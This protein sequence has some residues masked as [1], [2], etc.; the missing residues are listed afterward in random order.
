MSEASSSGTS[1]QAPTEENDDSIQAS[2]AEEKAIHVL[3]LDG[4]GSRGLMESINL[5]HVMSLATVMVRSP[6][7][8]TQMLESDPEIKSAD[9]Q[10][11][12]A[13][14]IGRV[15]PEEAIHPTE[16]FQFIV[17]EFKVGKRKLGEQ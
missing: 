8:I 14:E 13:E 5:G 7:A 2:K 12:L 16:A 17:G 11:Q 9:T 4:G 10:R 15:K 3:A 1:Q 6:D